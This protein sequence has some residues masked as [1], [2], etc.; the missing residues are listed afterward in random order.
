MPVRSRLSPSAGRHASRPGTSSIG[1]E[2]PRALA[3]VVLV[4]LVVA[5]MVLL[6]VLVDR[7]RDDPVT[8]RL[9]EL[10]RP[11]QTIGYV[12]P[13]ARGLVPDSRVPIEVDTVADLSGAPRL[14]LA[15]PTTDPD[16]QPVLEAL[17]DRAD[18]F[19]TATDRRGNPVRLYNLG[20]TVGDAPGTTSG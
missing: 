10:T 15:G 17:D 5:A 14:V 16:L 9:A 6:V 19:L 7:D 8:E 4:G 13:V 3:V 1:G 2:L 12:G 11:G 18:Q 20:R